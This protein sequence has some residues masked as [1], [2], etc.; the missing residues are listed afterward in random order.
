VFVEYGI[1]EPTESGNRGY[2]EFNNLLDDIESR[3]SALHDEVT[4]QVETSFNSDAV[5]PLIE[6]FA[7]RISEIT[8]SAGERQKRATTKNAEQLSDIVEMAQTDAS[9]LETAEMRWSERLPFLIQL[10][11]IVQL[12]A[13]EIEWLDAEVEK[14]VTTLTEQI[15]SIEDIDWWTDDGWS[16]FVGNLDA[17][18]D[19]VTVI[20]DAWEHQLTATDLSTLTD[21]LN[22]HPWL[23]DLMDLPTHKVHERFQLEYLDPL[24]N[25]KTTVDRI[26]TVVE[27]LTNPEPGKDDKQKLMQALGLLDNDIDW[28]VMT[29]S[30]VAKRREQLATLDRVVG[31]AEPDDLVGIGVLHDDANAL[32]SQIEALDP[33]DGVPELVEIDEGVIIK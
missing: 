18:H 11:G 1:I 32:R 13:A 28:G 21:S 2:V 20:S 27:P 31:D 17:R 8:E 7:E 5:T 10:E 4:V 24:R 29:K 33:D 22:D 12:T 9:I 25:F 3:A 16:T 14:Q 23:V 26:E 19:T 30:T 15:E 6:K